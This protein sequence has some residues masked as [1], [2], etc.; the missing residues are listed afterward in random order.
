MR[1]RF[2]ILTGGGDVPPLNAVIYSA[3]KT[4]IENN[5]EL[6][7]FKNGWQGLLDQ[8]YVEI[9]KL[10]INPHI[11]GTILKSSRVNLAKVPDGA[12]NVISSLEKLNIDGLIVV[13]GEDTLSNAFL[14]TDLPIILI[15]KTIDNDVGMFSK[16]GI[17]NHFTLGYPTAAGKIAS[18]V[19]LNEGL[20]TTAYSHER[21]IIVESMGMNAGWLAISSALGNP[22]FIIIPE[23]PLNYEQFKE[24][25]KERYIKNKNVIVV[26]AEGSRWSN[27]MHI[28]AD[29][30]EMDSF[31][32]PKFKGTSEVIAKRLKEDLKPY[33]DTRNI[34]S[35]NPSY[36]YRSGRPN[37]LDFSTSMKLGREAVKYL[38][39]KPDHPVFLITEKRDGDFIIGSYSIAKLTNIEY[40]HRYIDKKLYNSDN[41]NATD[42]AREYLLS[43]SNNFSDEKYGL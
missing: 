24:K 19:S 32:H 23:F 10:N 20:R 7:G 42:S 11:G 40:F 18:Y 34:N 37:D 4:A 2:G 43:I 31:G 13:G 21:I 17:V 5:I 14:L 22:D 35:V 33:F 3:N 8:D 6:I 12:K 36:L 30:S 41:L 1:K 29:E 28:S 15:S 16:E 39:N 27:N 26:V 25:V 38:N 9:S